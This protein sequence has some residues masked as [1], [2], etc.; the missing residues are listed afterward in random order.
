[1]S[2]A[3]GESLLASWSQI[4]DPRGRPSCENRPVPD[5]D[6]ILWTPC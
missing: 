2:S 4:S 6:A 3:C 5:D 1:M